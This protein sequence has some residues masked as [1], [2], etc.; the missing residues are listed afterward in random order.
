MNRNTGRSVVWDD[1]ANHYDSVAETGHR[2]PSSV[3]GDIIRNC[4]SSFFL[5]G[6]ASFADSVISY[7]PGAPGEKTGD[8]PDLKHQK[9]ASS[10]GIPNYDASRD[11]GSVSLGRGGCIVLK[12]SDN[13]LIDGTGLDLAV[14][15]SDSNS[16]TVNV[17]ISQDGIVYRSIGN[18]SKENPFVDIFPYAETDTRYAYV[19]L[20]DNS[21]DEK[22]MPKLGADI[23]AVG[24]INTALI[25]SV[26]ADSLVISE[27]S[28]FGPSAKKYLSPVADRIRQFP[29]AT[30]LIEAHT[31]D[32]GSE[33]YNLIVSQKWSGL[34][35][36]YFLDEEQLTD[37][38]FRPIGYGES[39]PR[40]PNISEKAR[41]ENRRIEIL[42]I[43]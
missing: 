16:E 27:T 2:Y 7:D 9:T 15:L 30:I 25:F 21:N 28:G 40:F 13:L 34:V 19:K 22:N 5:M 32:R 42:I 37:I 39:R 18:V 20:R 3:M 10:L 6:A 36:G 8:E 11:T 41:R 14:F 43:R 33:N 12:F 26:P 1:S 17:L 24:A 38:R 23:D 4:W 35:R 29:G 31:D